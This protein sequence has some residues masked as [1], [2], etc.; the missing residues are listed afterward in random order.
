MQSDS[1]PL[2]HDDEPDP[3]EVYRPDGNGPFFFTCEHAGRRLPRQL[4]TLG[5]SETDRQR[6]IA[7]DIG[8]LDVSMALADHFD[9]PLLHQRYSRLVIDCN[10]RPEA[11]DAIVTVSEETEVPGNIGLSEA[12]RRQRV[13]EIFEPYHRAALDVITARKQDNTPPIHIAMHSFTPV[14]KGYRRPW[15]L[16]I[17]YDRHTELASRMLDYFRRE[18]DLVLGDNEPYGINRDNDFSIPVLGDGCGL[19]NVELEIRQDLIA[20]PESARHFAGIVA[21]ALSGITLPVQA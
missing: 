21:A 17:L 4:G 14:F 1:S 12:A 9:A 3:V 19:V 2:L 11:P 16:G 10:R 5:L 8:A 15:D 6:H 18:T 13:K 7:W 20:T